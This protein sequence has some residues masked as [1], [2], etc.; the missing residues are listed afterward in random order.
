MD[1]RTCLHALA[2]ATT[3]LSSPAVFAAQD[4]LRIGLT[5]VI[6]ADQMAFLSKWGRYLSERVGCQ[7]EFVSRESYQAILD[8][9]FSGQ[10]DTDLRLPIRSF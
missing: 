5:P 4:R 2:G 9:L 1:R 10:I 6:L 7:V 8:L 3:S